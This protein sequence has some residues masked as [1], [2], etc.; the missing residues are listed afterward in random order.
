MFFYLGQLSAWQEKTKKT[1]NKWL[2]K[3]T[4]CTFQCL[5]WSFVQF[6]VQQTQLKKS[7]DVWQR[8]IVEYDQVRAVLREHSSPVFFASV[9]IFSSPD[10]HCVADRNEAIRMQG[11]NLWQLPRVSP[12][13]AYSLSKTQHLGHFSVSL[14][15]TL[16]VMSH[17]N[18]MICLSFYSRKP[19]FE[20]QNDK[21]GDY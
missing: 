17:F 7:C 10:G 14:I 8:N 5:I 12:P 1:K 6:S 4:H 16:T 19:L 3:K 9:T 18:Q 2:W 15:S 20:R 21:L 11:I 13:S